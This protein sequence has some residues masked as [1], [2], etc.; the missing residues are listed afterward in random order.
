MDYRVI[1]FG[2]VLLIYGFVECLIGKAF[3]PA[4]PFFPDEGFFSKSKNKG[5]YWV[6]VISKLLLGSILVLGAVYKGL[7]L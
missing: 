3:V 7:F 6:L 4:F 5:A 2:A 1:V